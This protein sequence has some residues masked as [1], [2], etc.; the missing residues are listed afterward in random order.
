[1]HP[2]KAAKKLQTCIDKKIKWSNTWR[3]QLNHS[4]SSSAKQTTT[5]F[6]VTTHHKTA[7]AKSQNRENIQIPG[8]VTFEQD[9][10]WTIHI[11]NMEEK[12]YQPPEIPVWEE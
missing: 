7:W 6:L 11:M 8:G 1:M 5:F 12:I 2:Q 9:M 4:V 10:K 3:V